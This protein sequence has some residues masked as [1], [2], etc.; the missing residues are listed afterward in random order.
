MKIVEVPKER[1][2]AALGTAE[3][4]FEQSGWKT[5][6]MVT[7]VGCAVGQF[8]YAAVTAVGGANGGWSDELDTNSAAQRDHPSA[9]SRQCLALLWQILSDAGFP[10]QF[11]CDSWAVGFWR[12][13]H[14]EHTA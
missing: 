14:E 10:N 6:P 11:F 3:K 4:S 7:P 13:D 5:C 2:Q 8:K 12:A 9:K 1:R